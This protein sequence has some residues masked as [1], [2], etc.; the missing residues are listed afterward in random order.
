MAKDANLKT[1]KQRVASSTLVLHNVFYSYGPFLT[2]RQLVIPIFSTV[3]SSL[4]GKG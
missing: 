2:S 1:L 4:N 3:L